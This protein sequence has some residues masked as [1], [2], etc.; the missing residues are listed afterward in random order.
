MRYAPVVVAVRGTAAFRQAIHAD[1]LDRLR[2]P[3]RPA[4]LPY[5]GVLYDLAIAGVEWKL[6]V[7]TWRALRKARLEP[8]IRRL[9][10]AARAGDLRGARAAAGEYV[11]A[12]DA[13]LGAWAPQFEVHRQMKLV[14][15]ALLGEDA[16]PTRAEACARV[17][18]SID[19]L[20]R[21]GYGRNPDVDPLAG[22]LRLC[23]KA[24]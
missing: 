16:Q 18:E 13:A 23:A 1:D 17:A 12:L 19:R 8:A 5:G 3:D 4:L 20:P 9:H 11:A 15:G 6:D 24:R 14:Y 21:L 2:G 22:L 10:A 7:A